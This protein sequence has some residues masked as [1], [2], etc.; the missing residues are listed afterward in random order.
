MFLFIN[1]YNITLVLAYLYLCLFIQP[2]LCVL[3]FSLFVADACL[4][5]FARPVTLSV[6]HFTC[7]NTHSLVFKMTR[8]VEIA[9]Y[10]RMAGCFFSIFCLNF[11][12]NHFLMFVCFNVDFV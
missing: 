4:C 2:S 6:C 8:F 1:H 9:G 11:M 5:K 10:P 3:Y 12:R 7:P